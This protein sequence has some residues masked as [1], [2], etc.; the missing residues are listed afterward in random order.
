MADAK[1]YPLMIDTRVDSSAEAMINDLAP[2]RSTPACC[3]DRWRAITPRRPTPALHV[4]PLVKETTGP[5][6]VYRIGMGVRPPTRTGSGSSTPDPGEPGRDQQD[7]ARLRRAAARRE[8]PAARCGDGQEVAMRRRVAAALVAAV[9]VAPAFAQ[10][11][12]P[13]EPEGLPH[14]QLSR[15]GAGD[16]RRARAC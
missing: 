10:Q 7:P 8:R 2:A 15:A 4:T 9:L 14:R 5:K 11:Q 16:A 12:E 3:G 6:L 1:P 13:F